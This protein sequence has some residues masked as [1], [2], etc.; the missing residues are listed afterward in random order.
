M[1]A[2]EA[3]SDSL[4]DFPSAGLITVPLAAF[5]LWG[6]APEPD[7]VAA[8]VASPELTHSPFAS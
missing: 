8:A 4:D 5:E 1:E 6:C 2:F 7:A 3:E